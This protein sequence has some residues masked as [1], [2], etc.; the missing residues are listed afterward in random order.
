MSV[1]ILGLYAGLTGAY[2]IGRARFL[3]LLVYMF[4]IVAHVK[5]EGALSISVWRT[6]TTLKENVESETDEF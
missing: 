5:F 1:A 3:Y 4:C 6:I 2:S